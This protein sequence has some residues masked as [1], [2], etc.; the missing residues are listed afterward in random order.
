M[1][2]TLRAWTA[3]W[4]AMFSEKSEYRRQREELK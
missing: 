4:S 3:I 2:G 1:I